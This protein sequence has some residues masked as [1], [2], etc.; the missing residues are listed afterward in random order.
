MSQRPRS[1]PAGGLRDGHDLRTRAPQLAGDL[2]V[3]RAIAGD[4]ERLSGQDPV[5]ANQGLQGTGGHHARQ[6]PA[7]N[8]QRAL[9]GAG[10]N[11]QPSRQECPC[12]VFAVDLDPQRQRRAPH[13]TGDEPDP[14]RLRS[15]QQSPATG[16][17]GIVPGRR[18][19][20]L[21]VVLA[22]GR[23]PLID[24]HDLGSRLGRHRGGGQAA[25]TAAHHEDLDRFGGCRDGPASP[26]TGE[27]RK[28]HLAAHLVRAGDLR[29]ACAL[30]R[31]A[32]DRD[33]AI[34][35]DAHAAEQPARCAVPG[36]AKGP[37]SGRGQGGRHGLARV[38]RDLPAV[39]ADHRSATCRA[40]SS[41]IS[42][43]SRQ[44]TR[45]A[46]SASGRAARRCS[47]T[48]ATSSGVQGSSWP[49]SA[50]IRA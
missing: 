46:Q 41:A 4:Q 48:S 11:D 19:G 37:D 22:T 38:R 20:R 26:S 39:E 17:L 33:E 40:R 30:V 5:A 12:T 44:A 2:E 9:E 50:P 28:C 3:E 21:L 49:R 14:G 15:G 27:R 7:R 23:R 47:A 8:R 1:R 36:R 18:P 32:V 45:S 29:H 42:I 31:A 16:E 25:G 43:R 35:A 6:R 10:R 24:Q 13:R 34:V